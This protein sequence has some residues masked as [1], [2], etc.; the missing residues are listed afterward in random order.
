M[1]AKPEDEAR[2]T[3]TGKFRDVGGARV[4]RT[5]FLFVEKILN[6]YV[7][8]RRLEHFYYHIEIVVNMEQIPLPP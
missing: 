7:S 2:V 3:E 6:E 1:K 5:F 8:K 4:I